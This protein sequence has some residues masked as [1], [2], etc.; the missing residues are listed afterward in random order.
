MIHLQTI[1]LSIKKNRVVFPD[2]LPVM[3]TK[4]IMIHYKYN[5]KNTLQK[6]SCFEIYYISSFYQIKTN[7][8]K[9]LSIMATEI[10]FPKIIEAFEIETGINA[11]NCFPL[12]IEIAHR[13]NRY[14]DILEQLKI[15]TQELNQIN[16]AKNNLVY[17]PIERNALA[18]INLAEQV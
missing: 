6:I 17:T 10:V 12:C 5:L 15:V 3:I 7:N 4:H 1:L 8:L 2:P 13:Y 11:D 16:R 9:L 14:T 18:A